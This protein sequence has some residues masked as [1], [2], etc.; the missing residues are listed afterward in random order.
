MYL[1]KV[2]RA[3][4]LCTQLAR[5]RR[6]SADCE[7]NGLDGKVIRAL[8]TFLQTCMYRQLKVYQVLVLRADT[9]A[10][11]LHSLDNFVGRLVKIELLEDSEAHKTAAWNSSRH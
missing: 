6:C 11:K 5:A 8:H 4:L 9:F 7:R 10:L 2:R 3:I 1:K